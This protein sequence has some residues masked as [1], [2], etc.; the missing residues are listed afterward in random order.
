MFFTQCYLFQSSEAGIA[1]PLS[2]LLNDGALAKVEEAEDAGK[3]VVEEEEEVSDI[4]FL[5]LM[6]VRERDFSLSRHK[7]I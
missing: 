2:H 4:C 7:G 3:E 1:L 6:T 5:H